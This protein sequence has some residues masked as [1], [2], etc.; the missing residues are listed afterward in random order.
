MEPDLEDLVV[1]YKTTLQCS[2]KVLRKDKIE[3]A[4]ISYLKILRLESRISL[5]L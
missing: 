2:I 1:R 3:M 4:G 5:P